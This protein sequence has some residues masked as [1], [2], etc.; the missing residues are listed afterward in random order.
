MNVEEFKFKKLLILIL[1]FDFNKIILMIIIY[2]SY[3]KSTHNL[4][5]IKKNFVENFKYVSKF[6]KFSI[7]CKWHVM[8]MTYIKKL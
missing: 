8:C 3:S 1:I 5:I 4:K 2:Y 7:T 6:Q